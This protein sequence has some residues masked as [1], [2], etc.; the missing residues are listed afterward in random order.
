MQPH[1]I[2]I[3][4]PT[5]IG[6]TPVA[7]EIASYFK[8]VIVSADSRQVFREMKIGTAAPTDNELSRVKHYFV[9]SRSIHE[10]YNAS[11]YEKEVTL[12]LNEYFKDNSLVIMAGG[13]GMYIDAVCNGI[14][15]LPNIE[16]HIRNK[17]L[18][19]TEEQGIGALQSKV[20]EIDPEYFD[21]VDK[22]NPKRLQKAI[23]VFEMT[24]K[25]YSSFLTNEKK[26]RP[27]HVIKIALNTNRE[28]LYRRINQRVDKMIEHGLID[29]AKTLYPYKNLLPLKTVGYSELFDY[30]DG[31]MTM[32]EAITKIKDHSR[33]Y[34]RRQITWFRR[35]KDT[36]WFEP[37]DING[38][39]HY[40]ENEI[41]IKGDAN[42]TIL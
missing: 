9:Q 15:D 33:A 30:F 27:F 17:W 12:F 20:Q 26:E 7:I 13:S 11:I 38:I 39:I 34:A 28:E 35:D 2:V 8:T 25:P 36:T 1:L 21:I 5:G 10:P 40:I 31:N 23:E 16:K 42:Q 4:G 22:N 41:K 18:K 3:C 37:S 14:D 32:E 24:G 6:K 29:E 19:I